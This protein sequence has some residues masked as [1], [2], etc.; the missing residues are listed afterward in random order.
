M[1]RGGGTARAS[2]HTT[3]VA[4]TSPS[5]SRRIAPPVAP[6]SM[7]NVSEGRTPPIRRRPTSASSSQLHWRRSLGVPVDPEVW[8]M[9]AVASGSSDALG[10]GSSEQ[11]PIAMRRTVAPGSRLRS[12]RAPVS[13]AR[14][15]VDRATT[16]SRSG[17]VRG[18]SGAS[19]RPVARHA[20]VHAA[21]SAPSRRHHADRFATRQSLEGFRDAAGHGEEF[22]AGHDSI[23]RGDGRSIRIV[24]GNRLEA[25]HDKRSAHRVA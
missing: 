3:L 1:I 21:N 17:P 11:P 12:I 23:D 25:L 20:I 7:P 22:L 19:G 4:I 24:A 8:P 9:I 13:S 5:M 2:R 6:R 15:P 18:S 16:P 14:I 10:S